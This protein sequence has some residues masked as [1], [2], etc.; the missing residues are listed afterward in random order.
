M[1]VQVPLSSLVGSQIREF[2]PLGQV[3]C[4]LKS[5]VNRIKSMEASSQRGYAIVKVM[6]IKVVLQA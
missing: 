3:S 4:R 6:S 2:C 5:I 1:T